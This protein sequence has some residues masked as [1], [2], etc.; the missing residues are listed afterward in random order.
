MKIIKTKFKD[1]LVIR[2]KEHY[3]KRGFFR[4]IYKKNAIKEKFIFECIS[5]SKKNVIRGLH[6][7]YKSTQAHLVTIIS[8]KIF[9]VALDLRKNSK[10]FGKV[11]TT[12]LSK[13][14]NSSIFIPRG[15][16]HGFCALGESNIVHYKISNFTNKKYECGIIW[17]DKDIKIKWPINKPLISNKDKKNISFKK[18][19]KKFNLK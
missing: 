7:Q 9:D 19:I 3:D 15:F 18:F 11:F 8:G 14:K 10:T 4:E 13:S 16:A 17:N 12:T 1:L 6:Y 5:Y 2:E